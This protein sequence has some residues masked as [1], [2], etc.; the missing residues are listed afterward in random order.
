MCHVR[1]W[2]TTAAAQTRL[3]RS[4][5]AWRE[6]GPLPG[7]ARPIGAAP[8]PPAAP[9]GRNLAR[10]RSSS[11]RV[12]HRRP[13]GCLLAAPLAAG[14]VPRAPRAPPTLP[15]TP[16]PAPTAGASVRRPMLGP[17]GGPPRPATSARSARGGS[18]VA[19]L[20]PVRARRKARRESWAIGARDAGRLSVAEKSSQ[21]K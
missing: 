20:W 8:E 10:A 15:L 12:H 4:S 3:R 21:V 13:R 6:C 7:R 19:V 17:P 14:T 9:N 1:V 11:A 5:E 16:L 2:A 18:A